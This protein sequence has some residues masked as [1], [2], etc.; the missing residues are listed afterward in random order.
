M[1]PIARFIQNIAFGDCSGM[2]AVTV[3][4]SA[5]LVAAVRL[6]ANGLSEVAVCSARAQ[7]SLISVRGMR[8]NARAQCESEVTLPATIHGRH[9]TFPAEN[10][11]Y[12]YAVA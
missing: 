8:A 2:K 10:K 7:R 12:L 11:P 3:F 6:L 1:Q 5:N 4:A 9:Q